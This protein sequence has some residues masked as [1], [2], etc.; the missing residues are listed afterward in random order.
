MKLEEITNLKMDFERIKKMGYVKNI[1]TNIEKTFLKLLQ[2]KN[3]HIKIKI[4]KDNSA[5]YTT[6]F[7][8]NPLGKDPNPTL[9]L[10]QKYGTY[11]K[12]NRTTKVLNTTVQANC[13]TLVGTKYLFKLFIN[14]EEE[15]IYLKIT[16]KNF[17]FVEQQI[18]W[19]FSLIKSKLNHK[20]KYLA[21]IKAWSKEENNQ[22][23]YKYYDWEFYQSKSFSDF[24]K[25]LA[26]G[27]IRITLKINTYNNGK[28]KGELHD[29]GTRFEIQEIDYNQ[30]LD[31]ILL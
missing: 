23:Y 26:N 3:N 12:L 10:S 19:P 5:H 17:I 13:S 24:L 18:Y 29:C 8:A 11:P 9:K 22:E 20:T 6:L 27:T 7:K 30:L 25:L 21:L 14:Y 16:D 31:K 2:E 15:K 1:D 28:R 4:K